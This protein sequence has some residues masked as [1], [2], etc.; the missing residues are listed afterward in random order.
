MI[1]KYGK[2][3]ENQNI[4]DYTTYKLFGK[5]KTII[6]PN[7]IEDLIELLKHLKKEKTNALI[8]VCRPRVEF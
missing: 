8:S 1:N 6:Y 2:V 4:K 5:I 7:N 3:L